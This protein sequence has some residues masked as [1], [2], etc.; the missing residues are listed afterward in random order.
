MLEVIGYYP[1]MTGAGAYLEAACPSCHEAHGIDRCECCYGYAHD[2]SEPVYA[3][4]SSDT[5]THCTH[6]EA[7]IPHRLTREGYGYVADALAFGSGRPEILAA[8]RATYAGVALDAA[9]REATV[10]A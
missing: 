6:C 1:F 8:W 2:D 9:I 5:P 3:D 10:S 4:T 7:I